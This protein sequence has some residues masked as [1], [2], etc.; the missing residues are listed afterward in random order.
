MHWLL[1][2]CINCVDS[3]VLHRPVIGVSIRD[4]CYHLVAT[5]TFPP[6]NPNLLSRNVISKCNVSG[7]IPGVCGLWGCL[8]V[9][10]HHSLVSVRD[11]V[12]LQFLTIALSVSC[13]CSSEPYRDTVLLNTPAGVPTTSAS[14]TN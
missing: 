9:T 14:F 8:F 10:H 4:T 13:V 7:T 3:Y 1:Y 6:G 12:Q 5:P 2:N 11:S